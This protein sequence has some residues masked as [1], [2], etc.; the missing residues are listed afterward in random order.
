MPSKGKREAFVCGELASAASPARDGTA[1]LV[2]GRVKA[3]RLDRDA[4]ILNAAW[5]QV[6]RGDLIAVTPPPDENKPRIGSN[7]RVILAGERPQDDDKT[8]RDTERL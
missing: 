7:S 3:A 1:A 4:L 2:P 5:D 8:S 6:R